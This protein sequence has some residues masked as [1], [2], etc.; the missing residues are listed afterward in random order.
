MTEYTI[1]A[2]TFDDVDIITGHR[3]AMF[4]EMGR[5]PDRIAQVEPLV[6][7]WLISHMAE[8]MY[9]GFLMMADETVAAGIG[10]AFMDYMP[11]PMTSSAI[12]GYL[13]NVYTEPAFRRLG[14][15]TRLIEH[16]IGICRTRHI[17]LV[18]L[19]ASEAGRP[20]YERMGFVKTQE[21]LLRLE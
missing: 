16:C 21:M 9:E 4:R 14:L 2:A 5:D 8:G 1:R 11:G 13:Y 7:A 10:L 3:S 18:Q 12:R 6:R 19:T 20:V 15:A 17:T